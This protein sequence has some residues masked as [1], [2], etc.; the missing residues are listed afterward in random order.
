ML[1][2]CSIFGANYMLTRGIKYTNRSIHSILLFQISREISCE[3][4]Q[5]KD[6]MRRPQ[7]EGQ[8]AAAQSCCH[9]QIV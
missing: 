2:N 5:N 4:L 8:G 1:L 9:P 7:R 3:L 6:L